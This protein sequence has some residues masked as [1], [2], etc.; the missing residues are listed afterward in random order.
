[1]RTCPNILT[2][3][4]KKYTFLNILHGYRKGVW[5]NMWQPLTLFSKSVQLLEKIRGVTELQKNK[6]LT[7]VGGCG[8]RCHGSVYLL[9]RTGLYTL[10]TPLIHCCQ[11]Q[12]PQ[13][14]QKYTLLKFCFKLNQN[15]NQ[16]ETLTL[17]ATSFLTLYF[18][19]IMFNQ[20]VI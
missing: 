8:L 9:L 18:H 15:C 3:N 12:F 6:H 10:E 7:L 13:R 16:F 14:H 11:L 19:N 4:L 1:M 5:I 20:L 2:K 17:L